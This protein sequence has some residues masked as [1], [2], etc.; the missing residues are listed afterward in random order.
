MLSALHT[1]RY[2]PF[3]LDDPI[4]AQ[5]PAMKLG[6]IESAEHFARL[7]SPAIRRWMMEAPSGDRDWV[8]TSPPIW[9]LPCGA[10]LV[11]RAIHEILVD[12][13]PDGFVVTLDKLEVHGT[14]IQIGSQIDFARYNDY[15]KQDLKTRQD[16]HL[17]SNDGDA[18]QDLS[19]FEGRR[20]IFVNDIN[21]TGTQL[22]S[23]EKLLLGAGANSLDCFLILNVDRHIGR[24]YPQLESEINLSRISSLAVFTIYLRDSEFQCTGKLISRLLSYDAETLA[25]IFAA[26]GR[27]KRKLLHRAI[28]EEDL[29]GGAFFREKLEIV[30]HAA[31]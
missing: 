4:F 7:L 6:H 17:E 1:I 27:A 13:L 16:F 12:T 19:A 15:S 22:G 30:E 8:L 18:T 25:G 14:R 11:C 3:A 10:N 28:V 2:Y 29:Y 21:V 9:G 20:A 31:A 5:Y 24:R 23:I 26:L